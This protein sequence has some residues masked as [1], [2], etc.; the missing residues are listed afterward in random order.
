MLVAL[1]AA[2]ASASEPPAEGPK[3]APNT[4]VEACQKVQEPK[5]AIL[6]CNA[7][8]AGAD[9]DMAWAWNNLG[10]ALAGRG[11]MISALEAYGNALSA[12]PTFAP[13]YSNRGNAHAA[14]GDMIPAL[15]DHSRAVEIDPKYVSAWHNRGVDHEEMGA[16]EKALADYR[17][18]LSLEPAHP[19]SLTGIAT[20]N[21]KL[22]RVTASAKARLAAIEKGG[23]DPTAFQRLLQ[24]EGFYKGPIDGIFGKGSRAALRAWTWR[25]CL[26]PA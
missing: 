14:L 19:G 5:I 20:A 18:A 4:A 8:L 17:K 9:K 12:D 2:L 11:D 26:P 13:A 15:A 10:L 7:L 6:A 21:C 23:I 25:G 24:T 16:Y 3:A 1:S 22:G